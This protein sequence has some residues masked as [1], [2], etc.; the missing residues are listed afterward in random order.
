L[1]RAGAHLGSDETTIYQYTSKIPSDPEEGIMS[2]DTGRLTELQSAMRTKMDENKA[3]ADSFEIED[4]VVQ[5]DTDQKSAFDKNMK[6]IKEIKGLIDGIQE[7]EKAREWGSQPTTES[8]ASEAA[9]E[10][11][12]TPE[13]KEAVQQYR[14]IGH[15]FLDSAEF[16]ALANGAAGANMPAAFQVPES[17]EAKSAYGTK[18]VYSALPTG[19]PGSFGT[20][21][22]DPIVLPPQRTKRVRDLFPSRSTTAAV[23]EYFRLSGF[24]NNAAAVTERS[25]SPATFTAKPQSTLAFVGEQAPV[26]TLAHWEA[27]H[28]NVLADEPQ[29]RSI[30][31][32]EL[33]YGLRLQEDAQI[34]TGDGTGENLTGITVA[35]GIQTYSWSAG[36][37]TPVPDTK[38]DAIRRAAT[39]SFLAYYEP[40]GVVMHPNDWEDVELTKDSN[41]QYLVAVSVALGGEPRVWRLPV[42]ETPAMT[43][44]TCVVGAFGT[45]AQLYDRE[46]P[47]IR[48]SEQHSDFFIRNAIVV[49]A[50]QR[51]ALAVKRPEAFVKVTFNNAPTS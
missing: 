4:G 31:D 27:A 41:G 39:L 26:R 43:E 21:Q 19:T 14:S 44:G 6:D 49:L 3:I 51:L 42:I 7:M 22:R 8:V 28:R 13:V 37:F 18:D 36:A 38:A 48:I 12:N 40:T 20:I 34:M 50:E 47:S 23:I 46:G 29:L 9:A 15:A 24:T 2:E 1:Y 33:L 30:I 16:K 17:V 32:N 11:A 25:G 35:T 5:V 10:W 45:G